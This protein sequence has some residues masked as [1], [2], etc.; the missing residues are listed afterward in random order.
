M[1]K[2]GRLPAEKKFNL[3]AFGKEIA[4]DLLEYKNFINK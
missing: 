1:G 2:K 3:N 4:N